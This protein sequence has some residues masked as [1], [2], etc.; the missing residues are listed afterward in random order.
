[1]LKKKKSRLRIWA[2]AGIIFVVFV[3]GVSP[4]CTSY[5]LHFYTAPI[6]SAT[7]ELISGV[8][9]L[10]ICL[11]HLKKINSAYFKVAVPTGLF[12][13]LA[14][15][16]QKIGLPYTTPTQ[17]AFL[18]NLSCVTVPVLL[19]FFIRKKP[20]ILTVTASA[21]CLAG[22]FILSG[23]DFS[24]QSLSFGKGEILCALAG[25]F[26]GVNIAGTGAFSKNLYAPL[27]VMIQV[28]VNAALSFI[29]AIALNYITING[30]AITP[31]IFS[32]DVKL[33]LAIGALVLVTSTLCW[34]IR[35]NAMK[36]INVSAVAV[37]MPFSAVVTGV[38]SVL[39]KQDT[40]TLNLIFGGGIVLVA[41]LLS[42]VDDIIEN[43]KAES[44]RKA[45]PPE[46][47]LCEKEYYEKS[48]E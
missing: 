4:L 47:R 2:Y 10:L 25:L 23:L 5:L 28:W 37:M 39:L 12:Y 30:K 40:L 44:N 20:G 27:Y 33:L 21:L 34:I 32:W 24:Q 8:A 9:L 26:Y 3:W 19:Y 6:Y 15:I 31:I 14:N 1:M 35:T 38:F 18:E 13:A 17:Y 41:S 7:G 42:A 46:R 48:N 16:L 45:L 29:T 11:P 36:Y 43:N 22:C